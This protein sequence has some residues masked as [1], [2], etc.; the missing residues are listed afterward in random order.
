MHP[1]LLLKYEEREYRTEHP[2]EVG[3]FY[4]YDYAS[5]RD[6]H[7]EHPFLLVYK[8]VDGVPWF[9]NTYADIDNPHSE[10]REK[11]FC[12]AWSLDKIKDMWKRGV[13]RPGLLFIFENYYESKHIRGGREYD[14]YDSRF[15]FLVPQGERSEK[16]LAMKD[17]KY[18]ED[19]VELARR[20]SIRQL[21]NS[22]KSDTERL[23]YLKTCSV[24]DL[25]TDTWRLK[26]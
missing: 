12:K 5:T 21:E 22:I 3:Q 17:A 20:Y 7:A 23:A 25:M 24:A 26:T 8:I 14:L 1:D 2:W 6:W 18:S 13:L 10:E 4:R 9:I 11:F 16:W 15:V 19:L